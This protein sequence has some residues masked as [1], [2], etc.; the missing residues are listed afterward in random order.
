MPNT[1]KERFA[2]LVFYALVLLMGYLAFLV[3]SPFLAPLA[4]AAVFAV[5]FYGVNLRLAERLGPSGAALVTTLVAAVLIV[6][7]AVLLA[8]VL[9]REV[10]Q[11]YEVRATATGEALRPGS[12]HAGLG[13]RAR[14]EPV[15]AAGR[16]RGAAS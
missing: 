10:P 6:A 7:P 9:A 14:A 13:D 4:W 15:P 8:S 5:M 16:T 12:D 2:Q 1:G 3:L 11:M